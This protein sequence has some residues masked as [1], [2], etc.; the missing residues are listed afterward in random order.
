MKALRTLL[1]TVLGLAFFAIIAALA[2]LILEPHVPELRTARDTLRCAIGMPAANS[3]CVQ[4]MLADLDAA[5]ADVTRQRDALDATIAAQSFVF[6][7]GE[8]LADHISLVVGTLYEDAS[9]QTGFLRA[10]CWAVI[11]N[12]GL[13]PRVGLA[14]READGRTTSLPLSLSDLAL[15][16]MPLSDAES[17]RAACPFTDVS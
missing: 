16:D 14:I 11:D 13:D 7:Q 10:Y 1:N 12:H 5:R 3:L 17:A 2:W 15:L 4:D 6:T 9:T 8:E